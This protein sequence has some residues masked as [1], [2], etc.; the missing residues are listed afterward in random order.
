MAQVEKDCSHG[1]LY[2]TSYKF[3]T[4][5]LDLV[6]QNKKRVFGFVKF[7]LLDYISGLDGRNLLY[8]PIVSMLISVFEVAH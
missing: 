2:V 4:H 1:E 6:Y 8:L 5:L 7:S 3:F